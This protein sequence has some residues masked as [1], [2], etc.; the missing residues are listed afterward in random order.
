MKKQMTVI[1]LLKSHLNV[2]SWTASSFA[3]FGQAKRGNGILIFEITNKNEI[4]RNQ[5]CK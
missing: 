5:L 4:E 3:R 1:P 2:A